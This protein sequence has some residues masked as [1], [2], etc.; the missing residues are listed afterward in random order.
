[1]SY[2]FIKNQFLVGFFIANPGYRQHGEE[3]TAK[4]D[5]L[6]R[7]LTDLQQLLKGTVSQ[8]F[9]LFLYISMTGGLECVGYSF[10]NVA[11]FVFFATNLTTYLH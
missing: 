9:I 5:E 7:A 4:T 10:A 2:L 3:N 1:M 11:H 6:S 8:E